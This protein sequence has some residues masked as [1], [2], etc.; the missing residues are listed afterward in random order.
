MRRSRAALSRCAGPSENGR[1]YTDP[2]PPDPARAALGMRRLMRPRQARRRRVRHQRLPPPRSATG[3]F[4]VR[5]GA[6]DIRRRQGRPSR[7][8]TSSLG[9]RPPE[10]RGAD[11]RASAGALHSKHRHVSA[12]REVDEDR[13][14]G[15]RA[16]DSTSPS[17]RADCAPARARSGRFADRSRRRGRRPPRP[18]EYSLICPPRPASVSSTTYRRKRHRLGDDSELRAALTIRS[19][20]ARMTSGPGK[21]GGISSLDCH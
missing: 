3:R 1:G 20:A 10:P 15:A 7:A 4:P 5:T 19:S 6:A 12:L 13:I 9:R 16:L 2:A 14:G 18:G 8:Q 11:P 17:A 21:S